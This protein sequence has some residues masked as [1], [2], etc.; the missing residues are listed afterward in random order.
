MKKI[1]L[2]VDGNEDVAERERARELRDL[3][4]K[5][6]VSGGLTGLLLLGVMV[7][8]APEG[9]RNLWLMWILA[10]PV[11][12]WVG[13][14][15]YQSAWSGLKNRAANMD[16]LIALGTSVAYFFSVAVVLFGESFERMG[17]VADAYFEVSATIISLI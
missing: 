17:V 9:L 2:M 1:S 12:F 16:T 6:W 14:Q 3:K 8:G 13:W 5:L 15:Y 10:T 4:G 11:Q 7:P